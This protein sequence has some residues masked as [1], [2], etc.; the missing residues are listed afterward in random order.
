ME[1]KEKEWEW[2]KE[3]DVTEKMYNNI[4]M[5]FFKFYLLFSLVSLKKKEK[6][7]SQ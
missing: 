5:V 6:K 2:K 1:R 4:K 3:K 7:Y